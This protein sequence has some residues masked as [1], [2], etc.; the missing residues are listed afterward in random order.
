MNDVANL[1]GPFVSLFAAAAAVISAVRAHRS[2]ERID[3]RRHEAEHLGAL[4]TSFRAEYAEFMAAW[5]LQVTMKELTP[6]LFRGE[7]LSTHP[8][9]SAELQHGLEDVLNHLVRSLAER[10]NVGDEF[11]EQMAAVSH[12]VRRICA[13]QTEKRARLYSGAS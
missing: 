1:L 3:R 5:P 9:A 2:A 4:I 13:S 10:R 7:V 8:L 11:N 6:V 12:E